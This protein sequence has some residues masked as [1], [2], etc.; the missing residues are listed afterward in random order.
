[1]QACACPQSQQISTR[2]DEVQPFPTSQ[3]PGTRVEMLEL[4]CWHSIARVGRCHW[5][6]GFPRNA[7][8][9]RCLQP[10]VVRLPATRRGASPTEPKQAVSQGPY[11]ELEDPVYCARG[12][13]ACAACTSP[14]LSSSRA[15]AKGSRARISRAQ[16]YAPPPRSS[17]AEPKTQWSESRK[18][19]PIY[20][21]SATPSTLVAPIYRRPAWG[22]LGVGEPLALAEGCR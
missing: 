22:C 3:L 12:A 13:K 16:E 1:M 10:N 15:R 9:D 4:R 14:P 20:S 21:S 6:L 11:S 7:G 18:R 5:I 8:P 2:T 17:R 19:Q